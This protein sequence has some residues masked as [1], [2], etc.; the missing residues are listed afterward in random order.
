MWGRLKLKWGHLKCLVIDG[1]KITDKNS[2][3]LF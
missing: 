2:F 1:K 3:Y